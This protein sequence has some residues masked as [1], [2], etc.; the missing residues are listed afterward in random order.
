MVL[1]SRFGST[2]CLI[3]D[4]DTLFNSKKVPRKSEEPRLIMN[5]KMTSKFRACCNPRSRNRRCSCNA[6]FR[7]L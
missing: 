6:G 5:L 7:S 3:C 4:F 1:K 2:F